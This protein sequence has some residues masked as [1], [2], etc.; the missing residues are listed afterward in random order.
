M[1]DL[2]FLICRRFSVPPGSVHNSSQVIASRMVADDFRSAVGARWF[3][4]VFWAGGYVTGPTTG[5][6]TRSLTT[7]HSPTLSQNI[8]KMANW[9]L[10]VQ[11]CCS[12]LYP[13]RRC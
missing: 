11:H 8:H 9:P 12:N 7:H 2:L 5:G 3:N 6:R 4:D 1:S 10:V 13:S